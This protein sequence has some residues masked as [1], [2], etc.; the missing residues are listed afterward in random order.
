MSMAVGGHALGRVLDN[1]RGGEQRLEGGAASECEGEVACCV[2]RP[3][4][5]ARDGLRLLSRSSSMQC[6]R[7]TKTGQRS[8]A[9]R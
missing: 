2:S 8:A 9:W 6:D 3:V 7:H 5:M 1:F 4:L